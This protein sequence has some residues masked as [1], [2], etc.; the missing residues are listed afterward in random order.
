MNGPFRFSFA[1]FLL[2]ALFVMSPAQSAEESIGDKLKKVFPGATPTPTPHK[3]KKSTTKKRIGVIFTKSVGEKE[4]LTVAL[5][6]TK[7]E[8]IAN[9]GA[10]PNPFGDGYAHP[11]AFTYRNRDSRK[12]EARSP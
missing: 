12:N 11:F 8:I 10:K 1:I 2:V 5:S 6:K 9:P 7:K 3:K 4:I